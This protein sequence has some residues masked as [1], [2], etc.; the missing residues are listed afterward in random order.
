VVIVVAVLAFSQLRGAPRAFADPTRAA[1]A[2]EQAGSFTFETTSKLF[3][4]SRLS[5]TSTVGG[6][7]DLAG[8]GSFK[9]HVHSGG[10]GFERIVFPDRVYA[11][12]IGRHGASAWLGATLSPKVSITP[13]STSGGG[14]GD[15]LGLTA[16]L[17]THRGARDLGSKEIEG[18]RTQHYSLTLTLGSFLPADSAVA[19]ATRVIPV[20]VQVW[21]ERLQRLVL[22]VRTFRIGGPNRERLVVSTHFRNYGQPTSFEAPHTPLVGTQPL[23]ATA[24]DPL[25]ASVLHAL[26]F[27]TGH[28]GTPAA[29]PSVSGHPSGPG[30]GFRPTP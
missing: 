23:N 29:Q 28:G 4:G 17:H 1:A 27:G 5:R 6:E 18:E 22:A 2:A 12:G 10:V 20:E 9:V 19:A 30:K 15:P 14:L 24:D 21:Q 8:T 13:Y 26:T 11:R 25:G 3:V 7:I 16:V